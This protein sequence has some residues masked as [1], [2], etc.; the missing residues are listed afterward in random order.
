M[1]ALVHSKTNQAG[2]DRPENDKPVM[3][4]AA[5]AL[6]DWLAASGIEDS[7]IFRRVRRGGPVGGALSPSAVREIVKKRCALAGIEGNYSAHSRRSGFVT[8]A[9]LIELPIADTMA[10]SG[11]RSVQS[12]L[13]YRRGGATRRVALCLL[14]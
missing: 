10:L 1:Y 14:S 5:Q 9:K 12:L 11:H 8:E 2:E 4:A 3:G 13:G 7:A 6:R